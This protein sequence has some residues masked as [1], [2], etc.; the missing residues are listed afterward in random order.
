M[1]CGRN[2]PRRPRVGEDDRLR[3][4]FK[5]KVDACMWKINGERVEHLAEY[6]SHASTLWFGSTL[7]LNYTRYVACWHIC[8]K[9]GGREL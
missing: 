2:L 1:I 6:I 4:F 8:Y 9:K 3:I 7:V 5:S